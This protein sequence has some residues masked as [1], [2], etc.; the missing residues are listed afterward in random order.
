M[1]PTPAQNHALP[2]QPKP[3]DPRN[4]GIGLAVVG[5]AAIIAFV[6]TIGIF[7]PAIG[8]IVEQ[9]RTPVVSD[10][11]SLPGMILVCDREYTR[12]ATSEPRTLAAV[13]AGGDPDPAVVSGLPTGGCP[14]GV[15]VEDGMCSTVVYVLAGPDHYVAYELQGGP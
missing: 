4:R 2:P 8:V 14:T 7:V 12:S 11:A 9:A 3:A 13:R 1:P 6:V 15:C 10:P 5:A